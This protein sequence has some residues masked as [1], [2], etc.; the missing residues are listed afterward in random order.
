MSAHDNPRFWTPGLAAGAVTLDEAQA[1]YAL[2]VL[3]LKPGAAVELFDGLGL[4][5]R[6]RIDQATRREV[7]LAVEELL[8][9]SLPPRPA[10]HLAFAVPKGKRLDWLLEK[11]TEL[12]AAS[13]QAVVFQRSVAGGDELSHAKYQRWLDHCIAAARQCELD[14]LPEI[15]PMAALDALLAAAPGPL[16]L[17]GSPEPSARGLFEA[18]PAT[19]PEDVQILV[20]PEGG[21]T[22]DESARAIGAGFI[23]VRVGRTILRVETAAMA[24][25]AAVTARYS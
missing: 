23:P 8:S 12:A 20:G 6:G 25:T 15:R 5:A 9:P 24:M 18:L 1:H 3:R 10:V 11:A 7:V 2:H 14:R 13:L 17:L 22:D 21:L 4:R 16:R 19:P